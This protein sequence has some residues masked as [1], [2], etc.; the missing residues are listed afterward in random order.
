MKKP[1]IELELPVGNVS[2]ER[3]L[4]AYYQDFTQAMHHF[5]ENY[6]G[7]FDQNGIPMAGFGE[8]AFY[9]QI[10][11]IQY[12][13]IAHDLA[14]KGVDV[15]V[16]EHRMKICVNWLEEHEEQDASGNILWK[17]DFDYPRYH[18]KRGWVSA[19]Y[20]GQAMSLYLRYGQ[21]TK[22]ENYFTSKAEK[23]A[24]FFKKD[25][26]NGGVSRLDK[27]GN[28]WMEEY[29]SPT[30]SFVLNGF[31]Y[32]LFGIIDLYR[33][34]KKEETNQL[35]KE[36]FKTLIASLHLY[37][38]GYWSVYDQ[39]HKELA[40]KYYHKNIHIPLM[41]ILFSLTNDEIFNHYAKR[42]EKQ[43]NLPFRYSF[44]KVMYRVR[45]RMQKLL[46]K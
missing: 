28:F 30:P 13:L 6:F 29:P 16:N 5:D 3:I 23:I 11:I 21:Y 39:L 1:N 14:L 45:P 36:S 40:S 19:M 43:L 25:Y 24:D 20:Q 35:M 2:M 8:Q 12:G 9:N 26:V 37:D 7:E 18:L 46:K 41:K 42:W 10:Y 31:I 4:G 22:Q 17:N 15:A 34:T 32:T 44:V 38:A 27:D 33:I